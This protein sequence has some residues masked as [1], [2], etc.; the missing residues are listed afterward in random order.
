MDL[1]FRI[2]LYTVVM[3]LIMIVYTGQFH[4][5]PR[6][7]L[8]DSVR[9]TVKFVLWTAVLVVVMEISFYFFID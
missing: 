1:I 2:L 5:E 3:F 6:A 4:A 9:K 7:I 8:V